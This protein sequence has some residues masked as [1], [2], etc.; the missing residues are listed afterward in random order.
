MGEL[1]NIIET[2]LKTTDISELYKENTMYFYDAYKKSSKTVL[3]ITIT[4]I[5]TGGFYF[6]HYLDDSNWMRYSPIFVIDFKK[7][8]NL[9]IIC[10]VN[11]NFIPLEIRATIFDKFL[12]KE[13]FEKNRYLTVDYQGMYKNLL[14]NGYEY[15]IVEYNIS[16]IKLVHKIDTSLVPNFLYSGHPINK[17]DP[18]ALYS[19]WQKKLESRNERHEEM[20]KLILADFYQIEEDMSNDYDALKNH[21]D[22]VRKSYEKY[23]K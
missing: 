6:F 2:K 1:L 15:S 13:D 23:G 22:R 14:K 11:F 7:F 17:Y 8:E 16:Q 3:N 21:A 9:I 20:M 4:Q 12:I 19:I 5:R 18:I 10:G